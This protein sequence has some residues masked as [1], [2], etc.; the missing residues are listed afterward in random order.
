M[1]KRILPVALEVA[2]I[3]AITV[4]IGV[5]LTAHAD[6][7][8]VIVTSGSCLIASGSIIWGKFMRKGG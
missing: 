2:G 1:G 6:V 7:G 5:E 4:G 3:T 8:W